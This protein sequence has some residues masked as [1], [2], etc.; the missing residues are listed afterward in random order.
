VLC[1]RRGINAGRPRQDGRRAAAITPSDDERCEQ[2]CIRARSKPIATEAARHC[3]RLWRTRAGHRSNRVPIG[4]SRAKV[5]VASTI[6]SENER[7]DVVVVGGGILGLASARAIVDRWPR[8]RVAVLDKEMALGAHQTGRNSGVIHSGIYYKP[9]SLK[10]RL[11]KAGNEAMYRF[12]DAHDIANERCG[13]LI[14][15]SDEHELAQLDVL[16]SRAEASQIEVTRLTAAEITEREPHI[17]GLGALW[18]PSTGITDYTAVLEVLAQM[19]RERDGTISLGT[20]ATGFARRGS[21][22]IV[23]T[24]RG[25]IVC[26]YLVTCAGLQSDRV[27]RSAGADLSAR[28]VPFR[29]E[30][31]ELRPERRSLIKG[32]VYPVPDPNFPFL[33]VHF[34]R[35][36]DGSIHAGPNAVLALAREGYRKRDIR[37]RDVADVVTFPG[38]WRLARKHGRAGMSELARSL[39][40]RKFLHSLQRLLPELELDDLVPT[41]AGVRAQA[42]ERSG[43]LVDDF[44]IIHGDNQVH[45]CN[46]PSPAAT[47]S[48]EIA[49]VIADELAN[50]LD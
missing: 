17:V 13:K 28:I 49:T 8:L 26:R 16:S 38:F 25:D 1:R 31:Y 22:H 11:C 42:L 5:P 35:M 45:V 18:V 37:L 7:Y 33:G 9:G 40:K 29:G 20:A 19:I 21:E 23:Q 47:S 3:R 12:C 48:L 34:T 36:I 30:Y 50:H 41:H 2:Y 44:L 10:S 24:N 15:A 46:A 39:S 4:Q 32:L 14:V 6:V 43:A 27:A